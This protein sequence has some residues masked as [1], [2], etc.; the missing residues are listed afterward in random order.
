[1]ITTVIVDDEFR[2]TAAAHV[3]SVLSSRG[4]ADVVKLSV[5]LTEAGVKFH[6]ESGNLSWDKATFH[7][8]FPD[9]SSHRICNRVVSISKGTPAALDGRQQIL[10]PNLIFHSYA[11]VLKEFPQV[12]GV[13]GMYSPVGNLLPL[14]LQWRLFSSKVRDIATPRFAYGFGFVKIDI[15]DF[16]QP[17][18]KSP[19]DLYGWKPEEIKQTRI[20]PFVVDRPIGK[21]VFLYFV[22]GSTEVFTLGPERR[23]DER[24]NARL[25]QCVGPIKNMFGAFMGEALFFADEDRLTFAAF[26][27]YLKT[28]LTDTH[29][30]SVLEAGLSQ[31]GA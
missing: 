17:L 7:G 20:H 25:L 28:S 27:H 12:W 9:R 26:S 8:R 5:F 10:S 19:F 31:L 15:H 11:E 2:D 6:R 4:R 29:F 30:P 14:T 22:G 13:P 21:P 24:I 3:A 16:R 18:W 1:M 23:I